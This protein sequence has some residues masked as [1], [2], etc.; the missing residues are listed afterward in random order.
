MDI[1]LAINITA[2]LSML[3]MSIFV[4][5]PLKFSTFPSVLLILTLYRLSLNIASTRLILSRGRE[6]ITAAGHLVGLLTYRDITK[7]Q[8]NPRANKDGKGR[9]RV[10]AAVGIV[11]K[12]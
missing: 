3:M 4:E 11:I 9:L 12:L 7:V 5:Q 10:A 2:G 6:G 1:A 8:E